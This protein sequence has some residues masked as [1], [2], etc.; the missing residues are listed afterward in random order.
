MRNPEVTKN[1]IVTSAIPIFNKKG[2]SATSISDI[3]KATGMTK[4]AIYGNFES[5][6]SLALAA[7]QYASQIVLKQLKERIK[8]APTA[9]EK[10][11]SI[12]SYYDEYIEKPPIDGGCPIIN[13]AVE[14]DDVHPN[15]RMKVVSTIT[16]I[17]D[18]LKHI[19]HRG[20][21]EGQIRKDVDVELYANMFY[22]TIKGAILISRVEGDPR[23]FN[24]ILRGL[25]NQ[26][27]AISI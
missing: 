15:L 2:Y 21:T 7:F 10:L 8:S 13:T 4:G 25:T 22:A 6:D 14:A 16:M 11:L 18:S 26:I 17:K 23:S 5:K 20:I 9:P 3:T 27:N 19:I 1:L 12:L 24:L